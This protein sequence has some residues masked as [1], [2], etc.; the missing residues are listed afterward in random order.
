[1][2]VSRAACSFAAIF[3]GPGKAT[4]EAASREARRMSHFSPR[5]DKTQ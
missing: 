3:A 1:L 5:E 2:Q 4:A